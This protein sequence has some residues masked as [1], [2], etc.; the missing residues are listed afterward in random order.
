MSDA[1]DA[2]MG[3]DADK[4]ILDDL[5]ALIAEDGDASGGATAPAEAVQAMDVELAAGL[6][7]P[8]DCP[9][10]VMTSKFVLTASSKD[11]ATPGTG[12]ETETPARAAASG[13]GAATATAAA[14]AA[15]APS[16]RTPVEAIKSCGATPSA[17]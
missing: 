7:Y 8:R 16:W 6:L 5:K 10:F 11:M 12:C 1:D 14:A 4:T 3:N 2:A 17:I 15:A 9:S 13:G